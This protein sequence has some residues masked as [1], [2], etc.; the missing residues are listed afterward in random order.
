MLKRALFVL[1]SFLIAGA[2]VGQAKKRI[3]READIPRFTYKVD[4]KLEDIVRDDARFRAFAANLR[5]D[6]EGILRDYDIADKSAER[7]L[8]NILVQLDFL[9]GNYDAALKRAEQVRA[10][11]EKPADKLISGLGTRTMVAAQ[12]KTG[13]LNTDAYRAEVGKALAAELKSFPYAV[14]EN[15]VKQFKS[16]AELIGESLILGGVRDRLQPVVDK[17]GGTLSSELA[18]AI[19]NSRYALVTRLPLKQTLIETYSA[20]LAANKVEKPDIWA[21]RAVKLDAGKPYAPVKIAIWDS[22]VDSK[23]FGDRVVKNGK[24]PALI[25]FD[26]YGDPANTELAAIPGPLQAKLPSMKAR[27]KGLSDLQSNIDSPEA[28]QVKQFLSTLKKEE[29][30]SAIEE[31]SLASN[32]IHGT[33]VAGIAMDGNPYARLVISR[34]EFG[35]TLLPDPCPSRELS[36]KNAKNIDAYVK[37]MKKEG[38]RVVNMSFGGS[39]GDYEREMELCNIGKTVEERKALAREYFDRENKAM[40]DAMASA[41]EILFVTA[42]GNSNSSAEF[43]ETTPA[44]IVLPNLI[45]VGAVDKAGDEAPFTSYGPTVK[46]HANGYQVESYLPGGDRL[47]ISGTSMSS[48]QVAN[49][50]AKILAVNPKL[51][52]ADVIAIIQKTAEKTSDGRRTLIHPAKALAAAS[53]PA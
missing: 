35:Y 49:L 38:V 30:K 1:L 9:E 34:I 2:A 11:E 5:R 42:A 22:G 36:L 18:P 29:Y 14:V 50:A 3:E 4:G 44:N 6:T 51:K 27:M 17:A 46:V 37:F 24:G 40:K 19:V 39:V 48:P 28:T 8:L 33:H 45:T 43:D 53:A 15:N 16:G 26:K 31:I 52:P 47:A 32:Y 10:L 25:A 20:Y 13:S 41:P 23:I 21:S 12:K 7:G